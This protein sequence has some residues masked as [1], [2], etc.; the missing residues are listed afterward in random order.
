MS[1]LSR[2]TSGKQTRPVWMIVHGAPGV[3]KTTFAQGA[4]DPLFFDIDNR[5]A[6][7]DVKRVPIGTWTELIDGLREVYKLTKEGKPPCKTVVI[8]T[9]DHAEL[10]L[11][12]H[13][14]E[15]L[16]DKEGQRYNSI[17]EV[18]GGYFKG[19]TMALE[20]GWKKLV[21]AIEALRNEGINAIMIAHSNIKPANNPEGKS[22]DQWVMKLDRRAN[23]YLRE[24][25]DLMGFAKFDDV[26]RQNRGEMKAKG[27]TTGERVLCFGH[28]AAYE[29]KPGMAI[30]DS[31]ELSWKAFEESISGA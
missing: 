1:L 12:A 3:G 10:L 25:V 8:D 16:R 28:S 11:W 20:I 27:F 9:V 2:M 24:K 26:A 18:G 6:H 29:T 15:T 4:P 31:M 22:W 23:G 19:Y 30:A 21:M 14:L 13:M 5:T 7:L 17:E